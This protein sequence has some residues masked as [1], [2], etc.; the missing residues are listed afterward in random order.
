MDTISITTLPQDPWSAPTTVTIQVGDTITVTGWEQDPAERVDAVVEGF[1]Q[2]PSGDPV[3]FASVPGL[4]ADP[5]WCY[6][7]QVV[8]VQKGEAHV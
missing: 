4:H 8:A 7:H 3:I 6:P 1:D 5:R 2:K